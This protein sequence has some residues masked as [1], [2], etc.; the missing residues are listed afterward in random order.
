MLVASPVPTSE[1]ST[2]AKQTPTQRA[3]QRRDHQGRAVRVEAKVAPAVAAL[4]AQQ[5]AARGRT[6]TAGLLVPL[7]VVVEVVA[8]VALVAVVVDLRLLLLLLLL[9]PPVLQ[10]MLLEG[11][12]GLQ[13]QHP[14][15]AA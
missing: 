3:E 15:V 7:L 13:S 9:L 8:P 12:T 14:A 2:D 11:Q 6:P 4:H 1:E 10:L 5:L